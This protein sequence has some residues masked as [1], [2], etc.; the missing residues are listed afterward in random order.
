MQSACPVQAVRTVAA[1]LVMN[2]EAPTERDCHGQA[3]A[4]AERKE[5]SGCLRRQDAHTHHFMLGL[6]YAA[7]RTRVS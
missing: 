5:R 2:L 1:K 3:R 7:Y 4:G 6:S